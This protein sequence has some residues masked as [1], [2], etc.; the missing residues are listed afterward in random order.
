MIESN[1]PACKGFMKINQRASRR[2][3]H[4]SPGRSIHAFGL[5]P[6]WEAQVVMAVGRVLV[7]REEAQ[8]ELFAAVLALFGSRPCPLPLRKHTTWFKLHSNAF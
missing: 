5:S 6:A 3:A 1:E 7:C 8:L 2:H 4:G